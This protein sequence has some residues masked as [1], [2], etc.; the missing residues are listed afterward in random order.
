MNKTLSKKAIL[1]YFLTQQFDEG[2]NINR[3]KSSKYKW[4]TLEHHGMVFPPDYVPKRIPVTYLNEDIYLSPLAE[5]AAFSYAKYLDTEYTTNST[6]NRNFFNDWKK[7]LG[8]NSPIQSLSLCNFS[9]MKSYLLEQKNLKKTSKESNK[10]EPKST[11]EDLYKVAYLDGKPQAVSNFRMEPP[12]IFIGRGKNPNLGRIKSRTNPEDIIINIGKDAK[13]PPP[14]PGHKWGRVIHDRTVEWLVAWKDLITMKTK[15][16]WLSAQSDLKASSD[17]AKFDLARKLKKK[18]GQIEKYNM[19]LLA[20]SD[21]KSRQI[22]TAMFLIDKLAIRVGNEKSEDE[23]DT[24]GCSNL[25]V[26]HIEFHEPDQITLNFLGK[27]SVRYTNTI[28]VIPLVYSNLKKFTH[29]KTKDDQIFDLITSAD[30]NK[31][32]QSLMKNL[33]AKVFRTY[34]A[35]NL[36]QK[37]LNKITKKYEGLIIQPDPSNPSKSLPIINQAQLKEI[38]DEFSK[39]NAKV[40]RMM[41]HQ[42]N[43]SQ[44]YKKSVDKVNENLIKLK[45]KLI[46]VRRSSKKGSTKSKS[47]SKSNQID[48]IKALI[49]KNKSRLEFVKEMK[50]ISLGTSKANY[51]DPRI[52]VSFMKKFNIDV[53]KIFSKALQEKF[54]WAFTAEHDYKF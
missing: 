13:I 10:V 43:I 51:I 33:T 42:K 45:K 12:G 21:I 5:E 50:N 41:N 47:K 38:L 39:A 49:T 30:I 6:F 37:E 1:K 53:D 3:S 9:K 23:A 18:I 7:L 32:L 16:L 44:G 29:S 19:E 4:T 31:Y 17:E 48:K 35:S 40:A 11:L 24:V 27:D 8:K 2:R 15:Y 54:K 20:T 22:A 36:F 25:R 28:Q 14:P 52:T 26:E 46:S 34:N